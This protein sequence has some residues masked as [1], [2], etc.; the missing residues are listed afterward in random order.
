MAELELLKVKRVHK[1]FDRTN[2]IVPIHIVFDTRRKNA[3][4]IPANTGLERVIRHLRIVH[5]F[6]PMDIF[7]PSL[8]APSGL[9]GAAL[10]S[11]GRLIHAL[12]AV[13]TLTTLSSCGA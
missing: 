1:S 11:R 4:L 2:R 12:C 7:L 9:Q 13:L 8:C 5:A 6:A 10:P 3:R